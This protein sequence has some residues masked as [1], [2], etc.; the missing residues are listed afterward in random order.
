MFTFD[1]LRK[2]Q[3]FQDVYE[4]GYKKGYE[5]VYKEGYEEGY[6]EG[7]EEGLLNSVPYLLELGETPE[8]IAQNLNLPIEK[9]KKNIQKLPHDWKI[10]RFKQLNDHS[11]SQNVINN[12]CWTEDIISAKIIMTTFYWLFTDLK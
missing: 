1:E 9:I 8:Q 7:Y 12:L 5:E 3:Y 10:F 4:E 2:T 11:E 6:K